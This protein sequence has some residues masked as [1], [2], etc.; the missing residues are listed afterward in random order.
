M[1]DL[2]RVRA[3]AQTLRDQ[4]AAVEAAE[5]ALKDAKAALARTERETLPDIMAEVGVSALELEDGTRVEVVAD[6]TAKIPHKHLGEAHAWLA[7]NGF[8]GLIK[9]SVVVGFGRGER[10]RAAET[11]ERLR[12]EHDDVAATESVHHSTLRAFVRERIEAGEP[13]PADLFGVFT[14]SRAV[15]R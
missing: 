6:C 10:D 3:V 14:F 12:A 11:A 5:A 15:I 13:V 8:G 2:K 9:T 4:A 1:S 7:E